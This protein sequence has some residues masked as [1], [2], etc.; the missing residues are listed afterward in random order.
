MKKKSPENTKEFEKLGLDQIDSSYMPDRNET[1]PK[2]MQ[3]V[4]KTKDKKD[5]I[6]IFMVFILKVL[7]GEAE[8]K[9][10]I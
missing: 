5:S 8:A 9:K 3:R 10:V 1:D 2:N 7:F 6:I 4:Q